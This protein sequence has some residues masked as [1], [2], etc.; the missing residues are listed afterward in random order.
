MA[1]DLEVEQNALKALENKEIQL[2]KNWIIGTKGN[3]IN[4]PC[5]GQ[6]KKWMLGYIKVAPKYA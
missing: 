6:K 4:W 5:D 1:L 3:F 2:F